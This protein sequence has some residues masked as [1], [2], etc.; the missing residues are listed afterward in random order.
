MNTPY[1]PSENLKPTLK[2]PTGWF[3]AGASFRLA[4]TLVSDGAFK[5]FALICVEANRKTGRF[6]ATSEELAAAL[7]KSIRIIERY[8]AELETAE[9]CHVRPTFHPHTRTAFEV[10]EGFWPYHRILAVDEPSDA[11]HYVHSV[12]ECYLRLGLTADFRQADWSL[13]RTLYDSQLP[14]GVVRGALLL[15]ACRKWLSWLNGQSAEPIRSLYY[16]LSVIAEVQ[17][18][19]LPR[20]YSRYLQYKLES[21]T[22][23]W[24]SGPHQRTENGGAPIPFLAQ[25][26]SAEPEP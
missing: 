7:G 9:I 21:F 1:G 18:Q 20:G 10:A 17:H 19:P 24:H 25:H 26:R 3:A 22:A 12:R 8:V 15:G 16:F 14:L 11:Q 6:E 5:L 2:E 4:L 13:A 23:A